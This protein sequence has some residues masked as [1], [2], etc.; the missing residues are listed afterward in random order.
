MLVPKSLDFQETAA[1]ARQHGHGAWDPDWISYVFVARARCS[2]EICAQ[3][4][5]LS[6]T[7]GVEPD[8]DEEGSADWAEYFKPSHCDPMPHIIDI[9]G[10]CPDAVKKALGDAFALFWGYPESCAGRIR[11]ALERLMD[12]LGI[13]KRRKAKN[14]KYVDLKLH[15]RLDAFALKDSTAG[16]QLMALKWVGNAGSHDGVVSQADLLDA[17]EVLEHVLAEVIEQRSKKVA[18]LAKKLTQKHKR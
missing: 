16:A 4:F 18:A 5:A 3:P 7:G 14:G 15:D 17:F 6:G 11:L 13:P 2:N 8:Y 12:H 10:K 9:P 1:S